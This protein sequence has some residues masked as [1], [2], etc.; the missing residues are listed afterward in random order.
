MSFTGFI[1]RQEWRDYGFDASKRLT[2]KSNLKATTAAENNMLNLFRHPF[3][4]VVGLKN[5]ARI[6]IV[7]GKLVPSYR[8]IYKVEALCRE[9]FAF[10]Q[11]NPLVVFYTNSK[12]PAIAMLCQLKEGDKIISTFVEIINKCSCPDSNFCNDR[13][14][15]DSKGKAMTSVFS[16]S[17]E[18]FRED[19]EAVRDLIQ[20]K[21]VITANMQ[22]LYGNR[23]RLQVCEPRLSI[24]ETLNKKAQELMGEHSNIDN[25]LAQKMKEAAFALVA[26]LKSFE[27]KIELEKGLIEIATKQFEEQLDKISDKPLVKS[28]RETVARLESMYLKGEFSK[29]EIEKDRKFI[30]EHLTYKLPE[31]KEK[32]QL[33]QSLNLFTDLNNAKELGIF[34]KFKDQNTVVSYLDSLNRYVKESNQILYKYCALCGFSVVSMKSSSAEKAMESISKF[35]IILNSLEI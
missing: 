21:P 33:I 17:T 13:R 15:I 23:H 30:Q 16:T 3:C 29:E 12:L 31:K 2:P 32:E 19:V 6:S 25:E 20:G 24:P 35:G 22:F 8:D 5:L 11:A 26:T 7:D 27:L 28:I 14:V 18:L 4:D 9:L 34:K 10:M 1:S